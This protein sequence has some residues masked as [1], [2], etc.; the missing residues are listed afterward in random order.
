MSEKP[1]LKAY[2][3]KDKQ[4]GGN[5]L[6]ECANYE[7]MG[8]NYLKNLNNYLKDLKDLTN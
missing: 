6:R 3:Y 2:V 1:Q 8:T 5:Y 4:K 7:G